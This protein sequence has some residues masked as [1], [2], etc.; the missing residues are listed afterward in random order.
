MTFIQKTAAVIVASALAFAPSALA[1]EDCTCKAS[2]EAQARDPSKAPASDSA[3]R[4]KQAQSEKEEYDAMLRW[5][6]TAP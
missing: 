4:A 3:V 6:W 1:A 5:I 2:R